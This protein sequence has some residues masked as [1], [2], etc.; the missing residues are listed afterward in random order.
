MA[1]R[2]FNLAP[3]IIKIDPV[4]LPAKSPIKV[5]QKIV[6][7]QIQKPAIERRDNTGSSKR[8]R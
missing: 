2:N 1:D 7:P 4:Y 5:P 6:I 8:A 3:S